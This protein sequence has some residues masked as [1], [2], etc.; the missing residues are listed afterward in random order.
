MQNKPNQGNQNGTMSIG[1]QVKLNDFN[2]MKQEG[3]VELH[4]IETS[5]YR[6]PQLFFRSFYMP[7]TGETWGIPIKVHNTGDI[8]WKPITLRGDVI[9]YNLKNPAEAQEWHIVKNSPWVQGSPTASIDVRYKIYDQELEAQKFIS[10]VDKLIDAVTWIKGMDD[11]KLRAIGPL[12]GISPDTNSPGLIKKALLQK[13]KIDPKGIL[14]KKDK[15]SETGILIIIKRAERTGLIKVFPDRGIVYNEHITLGHNEAAAIEF[16]RASPQ[17]L[18]NI[19][20]ESKAKDAF[21]MPIENQKVEKSGPA[22]KTDR[23]KEK[24]K[25]KEEN[26]G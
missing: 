24:E 19:D 5:K 20:S 17:I 26:F 6:E 21:H 12:F 25:E 18:V 2:G 22:D 14:I 8:Q 10:D 3:S 7:S 9:R 23:K 11:N 16:L 1:L 15:E 13:A 4:I